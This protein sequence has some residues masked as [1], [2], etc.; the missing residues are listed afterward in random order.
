[1]IACDTNVSIGIFLG[2]SFAG[3]PPTI[4]TKKQTSPSNPNHEPLHPATFFLPLRSVLHFPFSFLSLLTNISSHKQHNTLTHYNTLYSLTSISKFE[5]K[6]RGLGTV[7]I[8]AKLFCFFGGCQR[9]R[10]E[11]VFCIGHLRHPVCAAEIRIAKHRSLFYVLFAFVKRGECLY[12]SWL[13]RERVLF[14][15]SMV[16]RFSRGY[17]LRG[18]PCQHAHQ[19]VPSRVCCSRSDLFPKGWP[20]GDFHVRSNLIWRGRKALT[21]NDG[22]SSFWDMAALSSLAKSSRQEFPA[23]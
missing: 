9:R 18:I 10:G 14:K 3:P 2:W 23:V 15:V 1:V 16:D 4:P 11:Y 8:D 20:D 12:E 21:G 19:Q 7:W 17:P 6:A 22:N 13:A 5:F